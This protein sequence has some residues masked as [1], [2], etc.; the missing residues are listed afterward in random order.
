MGREWELSFRLGMRPW[1][2]VASPLP[3][4]TNSLVSEMEVPKEQIATLIEHGLYD[5]AEM[6]G[7]FLVS[8]PTV[9][10]ET[11]PQLKAENLILL[12]DALFHQR[13]HRRAIHTYKQALHHY[14]RIPKQSSG[15]SRSSLSLSTRSSVNASSI[16]AINEN[17][18]NNCVAVSRK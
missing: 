12:G 1:I 10:A 6:L 11:S 15:I 4:T 13:E 8:S 14:T 18:V 2:A 7:C 5:S 16:S 17:E 9:S 3:L